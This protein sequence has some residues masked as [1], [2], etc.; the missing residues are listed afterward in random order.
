MRLRVTTGW[1]EPLVGDHW[2]E[3]DAIEGDHWV[4]LDA[5]EPQV[6]GHWVDLDVI[7]PLVW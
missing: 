5:I 2:V 6:G 1:N 4:E 3:L 7:E